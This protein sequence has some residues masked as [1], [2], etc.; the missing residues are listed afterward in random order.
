MPQSYL[1]VRHL[2][3]AVRRASVQAYLRA[4]RLKDTD[5]RAPGLSGNDRCFSKGMDQGLHNWLLWSGERLSRI[6]FVPTA[7][8]QCCAVLCC[9]AGELRQVLGS[10]PTVFHQGE[11]PINTI[12]QLLLQTTDIEPTND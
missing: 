3:P 2:D 1:Q 7:L 10:P 12:G 9:V 4:R 6:S 8:T 5:A 11:G